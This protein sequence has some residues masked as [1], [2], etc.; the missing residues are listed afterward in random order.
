MSEELRL[1]CIVSRQAWQKA[2]G[3]PGKMVAQGGH[4]FCGALCDALERFPDRAKDYINSPA[5]PKI[6]IMAD[7]DEIRELHKRYKQNYGTAIITDA[8]RTVFDGPTLTALG[9]G[10]ILPSEREDMLS[11]LRVW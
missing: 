9:I 11:N 7:D 8:G 1:Y 10:P 5:T 6:T 4:A 2:K 3:V